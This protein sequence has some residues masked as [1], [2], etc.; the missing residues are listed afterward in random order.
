M[1]SLRRLDASAAVRRGRRPARRG[2]IGPEDL[3]RPCRGLIMNAMSG[4]EEIGNETVIAGA[5]QGTRTDIA[6]AIRFHGKVCHCAHRRLP[7]REAAWI[8][9]AGVGR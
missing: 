1:R 7:I 9:M 4:S 2:L 5:D 8:E 6:H 3:E